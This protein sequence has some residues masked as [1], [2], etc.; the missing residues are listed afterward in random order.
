M[1]N[2]GKKK[3]RI[4]VYFLVTI[5]SLVGINYYL[6]VRA[7]NI[8]NSLEKI[9]HSNSKIEL[10]QLGRKYYEQGNY[11]KTIE[12]LTQ[13]REQYQL[14]PNPLQEAATLNNLALAQ[15]QLQQNQE[16]KT[17]LQASLKLI[18]QLPKS[19]ERQ[20]LLAQALDIRGK[21]NL[22][23]GQGKKAWQ[24]W[25]DAAENY[26]LINNQQGVN[27]SQI[28]QA[29]ALQVMGYY[30]R[31]QTAL[32]AIE[33]EL[34]PQPET[35][36][37]AVSL[38]SLGNTLF[39]IGEL[40][41]AQ[42]NLAASLEIARNLNMPQEISANLLSLGNITQALNN[43]E[44]AIS[45]Y[46]EAAAVASNELA[47]IQ[48]QL[49]LFRLFIFKGQDYQPQLT[50]IEDLIP[51]LPVNR[52]AI[53]ARLNYAETLLKLANVEQNRDKITT[54]L[55]EAIADS[56]SL[57]DRYTIAQGLRTLGKFY[58]ITQQPEKA[59]QVTRE[60][61]VLAHEINAKDVIYQG[62]WQLGRLLKHQN[63]P[64][65][66]IAAYQVAV[67]TLQ[68]LRSDLVA[69]SPEIQF[70]FRESIEPIYREYVS[71]L[72]NSA[73]TPEASLIAA[74]EA[75]D[76]LQLAELENFF[77]ATCL[78]AEPVVLDE[79]IEGSD[80][81]AAIVYPIVLADR[82]EIIL[83]LPQK[84]LLHYSTPIDDPKRTARILERLPQ[85]LTQR[86]SRET[87]FLAQQVYDWLLKPLAKDLSEN[88]IKTLVFVL[89]SPLRNIPMGVLHDG[90]QYLIEKYGVAIT[91]GLQ[92][93]QP[94]AIATEQL[95]ALTAGVT[96]ARGGFPPLEYV[97]REL[98]IIQSQIDETEQLID[99]TFTRDA[100]QEKIAQ[101]P[102]P[103]VHLAT[104]G[105][106][107]SKA[108]ETYIL[109]WN[110]RINVNQ[111]NSLLRSRNLNSAENIE[112]LVLSACET[113]TGDKRAALGL[114]GVAVRAGARSTLATLWRVNDEA[115]SAIMGNFYQKL[116][117]K[118]QTIS[119]AEALRRAQLA[120]LK[121]DR[122]SR[123]HF[124]A[125]YV[126][127]GNWL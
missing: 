11:Q 105:Q 50:L 59:Q 42:T 72:L 94:K 62:Q 108:E 125:S 27:R 116:A 98:N 74:R 52:S 33:T 126:L 19:T 46:Q 56:R 96:E 65:K 38:R 21:L 8:P 3:W 24:D 122:F 88:Q 95:S 71:L 17:S 89:D 39:A 5:I 113:L 26:Q 90:Q 16:V 4:L 51:H 101:I 97:D 66:A 9:N 70:T 77:R 32:E 83:K 114:A 123:P 107:S 48:A 55:V 44:K 30:R 20:A 111:L 49:N 82:F 22:T 31:A 87:L 118:N 115:T 78:D 36:I 92:L 14:Q 93:I 60:S 104:H 102:F 69:V 53:Y 99:A 124:W 10:L 68:A 117:A 63:E 85:S 54:V 25:H 119:K 35:E 29:Q 81:T 58:E 41:T 43:T 106:F 100:L 91:P 110:D 28:N 45:F 86:N 37:K 73:T 6:S 23:Q 67:E 47:K 75:I 64:E 12:V 112:L 2:L 18:N 34:T 109:T 40:E 1:F 127:V 121:S 61:L 103:I 57:Q 80:P 7:E 120:L 84:P 15:Q 13:A 76:S 79:V